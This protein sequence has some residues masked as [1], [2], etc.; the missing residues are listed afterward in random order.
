MAESSGVRSAAHEILDAVA[1]IT[2]R[3][4]TPA[5]TESIAALHDSGAC[6][7]LRPARYGGLEFDVDEFVT[8][9]GTLAALDGSVGWLT[10]MFNVAAYDVAGLPEDAAEDVW[11]AD[12][13]A[14]IAA[15]YRAEGQLLQTAGGRLLTGR[16]QF[17]AGGEY[18]DWFLLTADREGEPHCVLVPRS[19]VHIEPARNPT[20]L[21]AAGIRDVTV[22]EVPVEKRRV[23]QGAYERAQFEP[24][25][26]IPV[27]AGAA[28]AAAVVGSADGVW[29][30]YVGQVRERLA[31]SYGSEEVTDQTSTTVQVA[32]A[33]SDIDA[34]KLQIAAS[35]QPGAD[36]LHAAAW[37]HR[38]A[39]IRA[40]DAADQLLGTSH[41]HALD[42]SDPVTRLWQDVHAGCRLT[43]LL[44]D[45]LDPG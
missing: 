3:P 12:A 42:A 13:N 11:S 32:R 8:V 44:L 1:A 9:I 7:L 21:H 10:A 16:W 23:F 41:R 43:I 6:R 40:R 38:Q 18:A 28:A 36:G 15:C 2:R 22:S 34:A 4:E 5:A 31:A 37:A 14:L 39:A 25:I 30:T 29:R 17:V 35:I 24:R 33:A 26:A 19:A 27:I 45:G 20:G